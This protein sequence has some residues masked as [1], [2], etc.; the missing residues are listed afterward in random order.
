[1]FTS[2]TILY[3]L[4]LGAVVL[5]VVVPVWAS[6]HQPMWPVAV[7]AIFTVTVIGVLLARQPTLRDWLHRR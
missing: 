6:G 3:R 2:H 5:A 4:I 7:V 1:M